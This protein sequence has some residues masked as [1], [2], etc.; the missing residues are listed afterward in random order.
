VLPLIGLISAAV[1]VACLIVLFSLLTTGEILGR[2]LPLDVP[3]WTAVVVLVAAYAMVTVPLRAARYASYEALGPS[4]GWF[5][6]WDGVLW[7]A[8]VILAWWIAARY[9]PGVSEFFQDLFH[10]WRDFP[11]DFAQAIVSPATSSSAS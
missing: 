2:S 3:A 8:L 1:T 11:F 10:D 6:F 7:L 9:V 4:R 5:V